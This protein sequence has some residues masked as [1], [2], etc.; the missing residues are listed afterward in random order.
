M[1]LGT[2]TTFRRATERADLALADGETFLAGGTWLYSE[3]QPDVTGVVDLTALG[4]TDLEP[5]PGGGLRIAAT[6]PIARVRA[7]PG[8]VWAEATDG[9]LMSFKI[10]QV[11]TVGGNVCMA[12]P[13]GAMTGLLSALG[14][15][16]VV[17]GPDG[18]ERRE[19]VSSLVRGVLTT[20]LARGEVVRAFDVPASSLAGPAAEVA[21]PG[22][23]TLTTRTPLGAVRHASLAARGRSGVLV[24]AVRTATGTRVSIT[25]ATP[26]PVVLE[27][28]E[29]PADVVTAWHDDAHGAPDWR[30]AVA[31]RFVAQVRAEVA[32]GPQAASTSGEEPQA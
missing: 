2:V 8:Q 31:T 30:E 17:W 7:L 26:A 18:G 27:D 11:A 24:V 12:L 14:A 15:E 29:E 20:S 25:G 28:G 6:C 23:G 32:A 13:A 10:Q 1:D 16:A 4:W 9:L 5:L 22:G 19:P 21:L 3:Q